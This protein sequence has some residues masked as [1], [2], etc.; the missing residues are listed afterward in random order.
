MKHSI[1]SRDVETLCLSHFQSVDKT[2]LN[3]A[4]FNISAQM[5]NA[6]K[7]KWRSFLQFHDPF[8]VKES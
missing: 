4:K 3:I 1:Y 5:P 6:I 2:T 7:M 8:Q